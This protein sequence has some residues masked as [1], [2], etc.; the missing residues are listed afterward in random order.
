MTRR[1]RELRRNSSD[2][3]QRLWS[4]LRA[5][6]FA[7]AKFRRQAPIGRYIVDFVSFEHRLIVEVDGGH[8]QQSDQ[9]VHDTNRTRW[10]ESQGFQ[11]VRFWNNE[12]LTEYE[13]VQDA[14]L[15]AIENRCNYRPFVRRSPSP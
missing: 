13:A 8:H 10:L 6:G 7:H 9:V 5:S 12:V 15:Q 11:V 2:A 14:I 4:V 1:A 3:E